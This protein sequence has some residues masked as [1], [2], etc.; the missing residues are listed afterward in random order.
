MERTFRRRRSRTVH[1]PAASPA[2][3][4]ALEDRR[5]LSVAGDLDPTFGT[6]GLA[7]VPDSS[8]VSSVDTRGGFTVVA[9]GTM[10]V[11]VNDAGQLDT[12][13]DGDGRRTLDNFAKIADVLI[14]ADG[15]VLAAGALS[16]A[17]HSAAVTRLNTNGSVDASFGA[18]GVRTLDQLATVTS[19]RDAPGNKIVLG[20]GGTTSASRFLFFAGARLTSTG[21]FDTTF[22]GDG[23]ALTNVVGTAADVAAQANGAVILVGTTNHGDGSFNSDVG[24][25]RL[26]NA[27]AVDTTFSGDGKWT[28]DFDD[29]DFGEAV[30]IAP[31]GRI[32]VG[33][34]LGDGTIAPIRLTASGAIDTLFERP[35][36][37]QGAVLND[38]HRRS[39][40]RKSS[41]SPTPTRL[42]FRPAA[43][44]PSS[45][46][47][48]TASS[49]TRSAAAA[50]PPARG[51]S[52]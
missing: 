8:G 12:G 38:I 19:L 16:D 7:T 20:G 37:A 1:L 28:Y 31:D 40:A 17:N 27:G 2:A 46:T 42:V 51:T 26:T 43:M 30:D 5:L 9:A 41:C 48:P 4:E 15:K 18:G 39:T 21:A 22:G 11:R 10:L 6:G 25:A 47:M 29:D 49:T 3:V 13:F 34:I 24:V 44:L 50:P 33:A 23:Q 14:Q 32:L 36:A 52:S 45:A 35:V